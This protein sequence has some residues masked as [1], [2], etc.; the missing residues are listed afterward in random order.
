MQSDIGNKSGFTQITRLFSDDES[1]EQGIRCFGFNED[2]IVRS[3]LVKFI[4]K[5]IKSLK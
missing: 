5:K 4:V 3:E 1:K 2:D